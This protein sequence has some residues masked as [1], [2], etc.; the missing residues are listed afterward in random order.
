MK[1]RTRKGESGQVL[2]E[3]T[4]ML[5]MVVLVALSLFFLMRF[6]LAYGWRILTLIAWEP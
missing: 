4:V 2:A 1:R 3:Y 6:F 5:F